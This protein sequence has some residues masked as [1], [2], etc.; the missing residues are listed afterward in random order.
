MY[1]VLR[2]PILFPLWTPKIYYPSSIQ[3][4][5][6]WMLLTQATPMAAHHPWNPNPSLSLQVPLD[7]T[8]SP[9]PNL[10]PALPPLTHSISA[11]TL[12]KD[13]YP[14][15]LYSWNF[16]NILP[17]DIPIFASFWSQ[18][19]LCL[20]PYRKCDPLGHKR[21]YVA[22]FLFMVFM[23]LTTTWCYMS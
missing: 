3:R 21:P 8:L 11:F 16:W 23:A 22:I 17:L 13:A 6:I 20:P 7:L 19:S 5:L 4:D 2:I 14:I 12:N 15:I 9:S 1:F 10:L 18:K